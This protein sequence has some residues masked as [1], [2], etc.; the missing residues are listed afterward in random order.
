MDLVGMLMMDRALSVR[1]ECETQW[2]TMYIK[3]RARLH[4]TWWGRVDGEVSVLGTG[5]GAKGLWAGDG[6]DIDWDGGGQYAN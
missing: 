4:P 6:W 2:L 3:N 5:P 1:L